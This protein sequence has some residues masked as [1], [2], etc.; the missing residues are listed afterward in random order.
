MLRTLWIDL[1]AYHRINAVPK[2]RRSIIGDRDSLGVVIP[3]T[4][5]V[6]QVLIT[7]LGAGDDVKPGK[8]PSGS[9]HLLPA[10]RPSSL[11]GEGSGFAG[12]L[13][14]HAGQLH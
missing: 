11:V 1:S 3:A 14:V 9:A 12:M 2:S 4:L 6:K 10:F 8:V 7:G 5:G 13:G